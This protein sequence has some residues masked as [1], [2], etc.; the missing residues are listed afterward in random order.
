MKKSFCYKIYKLYFN[1]YEN[2]N[3]KC[4]NVYSIE[5]GEIVHE[6]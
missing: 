4:Q 5:M 3:S 6:D 2:A 1:I